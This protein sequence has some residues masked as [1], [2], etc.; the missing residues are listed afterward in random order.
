MNKSVSIVQKLFIFIDLK[1][2]R[3]C[4]SEEPPPANN[5]NT[6]GNSRFHISA[7]NQFPTRITRNSLPE[8]KH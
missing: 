5:G 7:S 2:H 3:N 1:A 8:K 6:V 4:N